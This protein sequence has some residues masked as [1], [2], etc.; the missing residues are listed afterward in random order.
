MGSKKN[1]FLVQG[2]ILAMAGILTRVIGII[3]RI[4]LTNALGNGLAAYSI[5]YDIYS[6]FLLISSLSL[7]LAVS[8]I[9]A[10]RMAKGEVRNA[11]KALKGSL[12]IAVSIGAVVSMLVFVFADK[13]ADIWGFPSA[14]IALKVLAPTLF[15]MCILGVLRGFFQG[16]GTMM[17]TAMSQIF[18]Q[19][20]NAVVSVVAAYALY[21]IGGKVGKSV[22]YG[23]AGGT[24]GTA[25]GALTALL[26]MVFV[27][28]IYKRN[29]NRMAVRD[30]HSYDESYSDLFKVLA[31][32]IFPVLLSTT[33]YNIS[34]ILDSAIYGN[35]MNGVFGFSE[36]DYEGYWSIYSGHYRLLTTA[37]IA[38]ASALSSAVVPSLIRSITNRDFRMLKAKMESA[39]RLTMI[40]AIPCGVGLTVLAEPIIVTLF[41]TNELLSDDVLLMRLA[42]FVVCAYSFSTITNSI[43][44]GIDKMKLPVIHSATA[45][46]A[47]I[48]I[49]PILLLLKMDV[50]AVAVADIIFAVM[51]C[52]MNVVAVKRHTGYRQEC[53]KTFILPF[54]SAAIMG[55]AAW[56]I[57]EGLHALGTGVIIPLAIAIISA[58]IIYGVL[59]MVFKVVDEN[60][61][62]MFPGGR[63]LAVLLKKIKLLPDIH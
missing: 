62:L 5:A 24:L 51:V 14:A 35:I 30:R 16:M 61:I 10:A 39:I 53:T 2:S 55:G 42:I 33:I 38:V 50:F 9:V 8:K 29:F 15:V 25:M 27:Y 32:T 34:S 22:E 45:L 49:L 57:Y 59:L 58:V 6:L 23:A 18:E 28:C 52:I 41:G 44:Q 60:E 63:K 1:N 11:K 3:Y 12:I 17:P 31:V 56:L 21:D 54:I 19:I 48:I 43:L 36:S 4:P 37:P 26:F 7:P 13:L 46:A 20:I 40:I 47:H